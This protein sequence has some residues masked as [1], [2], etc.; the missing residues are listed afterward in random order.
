MHANVVAHT[1][2]LVTLVPRMTL[3]AESEGKTLPVDTRPL[4]GLAASLGFLPRTEPWP[5][6]ASVKCFG[7]LADGPA[8]NGQ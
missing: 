7:R 8:R 3:P 5:F 6:S 4:F 1:I 2:R